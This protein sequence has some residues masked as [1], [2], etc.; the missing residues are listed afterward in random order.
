[1]SVMQGA[2]QRN[3]IGTKRKLRR[4]KSSSLPFFPYWFVPILGLVLLTLLTSSC[5]DSTTQR[6]TDDALAKIGADWVR[7]DVSGRHVTLRGTPPDAA[8]ASAAY[9]AVKT[10]KSET[11]LGTGIQATR[12]FE[13]YENAPVPADDI[14]RDPA[15]ANI[16]LTP[17]AATD[18]AW[19]F[20][21]KDNVVTLTG[22]VPDQAMRTSIV[23]STRFAANGARIEDQLTVTGRTA[24]TG[25]GAT[26]LRGAQALGRCTNGFTAFAQNT[27]S[28]NCEAK[29]ADTTELRL[30]ASTPLAFGT[31][32]SISVLATEDIVNCENQLGALL[33]NAR[34]EFATGSAV[35][36]AASANLLTSIAAE[37]KTCPGTL[38][39]E[40]HTDNEGSAERNA[41]LSLQRANA[42]RLALIS[43]GLDGSQLTTEGF[44]PALPI[45]SNTT[46]LGRSRNRRI[47]FRVVRP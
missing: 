20:E 10:A 47:Q 31:V 22:E 30:L 2:Q 45:A 17:E 16:A 24:G 38:R 37:A 8:A 28:L 33:T 5:V 3:R 11:F 6:T 39:I 44:G 4:L 27:F 43:R 46:E 29:Q 35:I 23:E 12:V 40:G 36:N 41:E 18:H 26:A 25:Y 34:I 21:R 14:A 9:N 32:G 15:P 42:V 7:P 19:R 13:A 1:M